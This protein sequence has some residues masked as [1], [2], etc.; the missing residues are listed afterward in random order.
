MKPSWLYRIASIVLLLFAAGHTMGFRQIDPKWGV[1][2]LVH[3]MQT[4]HFNFNGTE[5]TYWDF[6]VGFGLFVTVL[7]VF[8]SI[9][10][11]QFGSLPAETLASMRLSAWGFA[12]CFAVV[13]YLSWRYFF[14]LPV[15][16]SIVIFLCLTTAAWLSGHGHSTS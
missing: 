4:V 1:D 14:A 16:F 6:Y 10:A 5:R 9:V 12:V 11:W 2:S 15:G 8:A 13:A 3:S 7:M